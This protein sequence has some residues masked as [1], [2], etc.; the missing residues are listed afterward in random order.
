MRLVVILICFEMFGN[1][2]C[3]Y[4]EAVHNSESVFSNESG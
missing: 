2:I 1:G 4:M 3:Q